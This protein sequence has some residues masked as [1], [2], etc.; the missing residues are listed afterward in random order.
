MSKIILTFPESQQLMTCSGYREHSKLINGSMGLEVYG[1]S[2]YLVDEDWWNG[3]I[4]PMDEDE[5]NE[6]FE[7]DQCFDDELFELGLL[8]DDMWDDENYEEEWE[9]EE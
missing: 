8:D 9:D 5:E 3:D 1:S 6:D 2:A 7:I 4:K